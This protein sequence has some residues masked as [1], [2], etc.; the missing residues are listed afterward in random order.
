MKIMVVGL[1]SMGR[2][3]VRLLKQISVDF[4][5]VGVDSNLDRQKQAKEE[6]GIGT[7]SDLEKTLVDFKPECAVVSTSPLSHAAIIENC[8]KHGCHI[9]TELNLVSDKYEENMLL[10][11]EQ[12]KTLFLS[13]T[14]LYRDEIKY[15]AEKVANTAGLLN[16]NYHVGQYLPDWHPWE[17]IQNYF[18]GDKRTNGCRELFAI[19]LPWIIK[20]FGE[21]KSYKVISDRNTQL[22]IEYNDNYLLLI[23]H[24]NGNK[25]VLCV[26]VVSRKAVRNLVVYGEKLYLTWDG[27]PLGLK[28]Y[29]YN[30]KAEKNINLYASI[31]KQ[32]GYASFVIENAYKNEL[33]TFINVVNGKGCTE[34]TFEEDKKVLA[35][36]DDIEAGNSK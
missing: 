21:I 25:G 7:Q 31:D 28:E 16:Y 3:R 26:D 22:P 14:F 10:A 24:I 15:V 27:T 34:Y 33:E 12:K 5:I 19:E 29:D 17:S 23:E 4:E 11:K 30:N 32:E 6:L 9:F 13:S 18:V 35:M 8:L 36:I 1:G 2:R 20:T